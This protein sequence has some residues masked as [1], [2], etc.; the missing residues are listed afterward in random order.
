MFYKAL[1][2]SRIALAL[3]ILIGIFTFTL[4]PTFAQ[5][6]P[7]E[8]AE[9]LVGAEDSNDAAAAAVLFAD[10]AVV[11]LPTGV[12]DTP[13]AIHVWREELAAGDFH[14]EAV[15]MQADRNTVTWTGQVSLDTFRNMG[16]AA[17]DGN[18]TL[19]IEDGKI[20]SF[21]FSFTPEAFTE[22]QTGIAALTLIAAE[23]SN[24]A[25]AAAALFA[26]D[27]VVTLPTGVLDT[28]EAI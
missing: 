24:D 2:R 22:L 13:E 20:K 16:I 7:E 27:A 26:D 18:W 15:N 21:D 9:A 5:S 3:I 4:L 23:G 19:E 17:L 10:D 25:A 11:T 6:S 14:I 28:P 1:L 8:T 12:L